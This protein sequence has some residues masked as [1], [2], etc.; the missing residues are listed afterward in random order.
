[1]PNRPHWLD[2]QRGSVTSRSPRAMFED[3]FYRDRRAIFWRG[4]IVGFLH[5]CIMVGSIAYALWP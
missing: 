4:M 1:M 5:G 2:A 3:E